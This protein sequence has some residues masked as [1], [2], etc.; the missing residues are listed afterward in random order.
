MNASQI[1]LYFRGNPSPNAWEELCKWTDEEEKIFC[2]NIVSGSVGMRIIYEDHHYV[3]NHT[4]DYHN[5]KGYMKRYEGLD[6]SLAREKKIFMEANYN[7]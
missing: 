6:E 7:D 2:E 4:F 1:T 3:D 5:I